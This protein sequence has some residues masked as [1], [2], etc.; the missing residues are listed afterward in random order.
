MS[1]VMPCPCAGVGGVIFS[2]A[3][4][5]DW[6]RYIPSGRYPPR[7]LLPVALLAMVVSYVVPLGIGALVT[8]AFAHPYAPFPTSLVQ[9]APGWYAGIL[10]PMALLGGLAWSGGNLYRS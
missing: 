5:G 3:S 1:G 8:T 10:I 9:A 4:G 2:A 6:T 7:R